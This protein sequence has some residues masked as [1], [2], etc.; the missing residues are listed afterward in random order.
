MKPPGQM[1]T[2][3]TAAHNGDAYRG[4]VGLHHA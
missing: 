3:Q 4:Q 1:K 2:G